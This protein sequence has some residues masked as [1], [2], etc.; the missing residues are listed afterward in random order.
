MWFKSH[1][2]YIVIFFQILLISFPWNMVMSRSPKIKKEVRFFLCFHWNVNIIVAY[3]KLSLLKAYNIFINIFYSYL[4][5]V[6]TLLFQLMTLVF[7]FQVIILF[8]LIIL[9]MLKE[10]VFACITKR[11]CPWDLLMC[12]SFLSVCY[13]RWLFKG[14][15]VISLLSIDLQV[16]QQLHLMDFISNF[17]SLLNFVKWLLN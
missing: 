14:K 11:I 1:Y 16:N 17:E 10:V 5:H 13:V 4:K 12:H 15:K 2:Y 3:K 8:N 7:H 9:T 6:Q